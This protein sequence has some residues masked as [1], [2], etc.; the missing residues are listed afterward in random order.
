MRSFSLTVLT[1]TGREKNQRKTC[2]DNGKTG[3][4]TRPGNCLIY[5]ILR[6]AASP[7]TARRQPDFS[8]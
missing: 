2:Q 6:A 1:K 7:E 4:P 8:A 3:W 5:F